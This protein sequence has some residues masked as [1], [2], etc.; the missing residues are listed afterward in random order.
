MEHDTA[1]AARHFC[2]KVIADFTN[3]LNKK[4]GAQVSLII[5]G[6]I[7][8]RHLATYPADTTIAEVMAELQ[9]HH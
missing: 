1:Q 6:D 5:A 2:E 4:L 7:L 3:S 9:A 8:A